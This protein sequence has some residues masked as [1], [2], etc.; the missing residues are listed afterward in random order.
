MFAAFSALLGFA[1]P[2]SLT[3]AAVVSTFA[4][5]LVHPAGLAADA[6]GR[7]YI[8]NRAPSGTIYRCTPPS[9]AMTVFASGFSD[10]LDLVFDSAGNLFVADY[11]ASA[12]DKV[13]PGG[14]VSH[15]ASVPSPNPITIDAADNLYVGEYFNQK[16][17]K[18]TPAGVV[19]TYVASIGAAGTR[20]VMLHMEPDG[21]LYSGDLSSGVIYK[22]GAGGSPVTVFNSTMPSCTG[23]VHDGGPDWFAT[24]YG[25]EQIYRITAAGSASVYAGA[26][27]VAGSTNGA[28]LTARFYYPTRLLVLGRNLYV[29]EYYN[30]D[31]RT[32]SDEPTPTADGTWGRL[33]TLYR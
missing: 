22:I 4:S 32:I 11:G 27:G 1:V 24:S 9:N 25:Y 8:G 3:S 23:F 33:K 20:L 28:L 2:P 7:M 16:I 30:N 5:G 29:S 26:Y 17:D 31:V 13:T 18:I 6:S 19:S 15:F 14:V 10:P 12:V 21:T